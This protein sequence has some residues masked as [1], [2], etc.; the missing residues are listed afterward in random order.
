[1]WMKTKYIFLFINH[2]SQLLIF[3][4]FLYSRMNIFLV[5]NKFQVPYKI[6]EN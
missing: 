5:T 4:H 1:M 2:I 3:P 6:L